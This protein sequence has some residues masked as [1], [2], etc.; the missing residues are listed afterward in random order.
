MHSL[1]LSFFAVVVLLI[2]TGNK[3]N[4][5]VKTPSQWSHRMKL[6]IFVVYTK[7]MEMLVAIKIAPD[8]SR[9]EQI[10]IVQHSTLLI[11]PK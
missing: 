1:L 9:T 11:I 2:L 5:D 3:P 8:K 7:P 4:I 10:S 6:L